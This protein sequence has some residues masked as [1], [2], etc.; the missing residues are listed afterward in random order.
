MIKIQTTN[1]F[2]KF[3]T[4]ALEKNH[5]KTVW[6]V[7]NLD[8]KEWDL[9]TDQHENYIKYYEEFY[10]PKLDVKSERFTEWDNWDDE[11]NY[12]PALCS[13]S[14]EIRTLLPLIENEITDVG[15]KEL[16]REETSFLR[17]ISS[18]DEFNFL[19]ILC[20]HL[21]E[22]KCELP[23]T[24]AHE[25]IHIIDLINEEKHKGEWVDGQAAKYSL[26]CKDELND[27]YYEEFL[28][29]DL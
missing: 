20:N 7:V 29:Y 19:I 24:I 18:F 4:C 1:E 6:K 26:I 2:N 11:E 9:Y 25:V 17:W 15:T 22:F 3:I 23:L 12:A 10:E 21:Q 16:F 28:K 8:K 14:Y 27:D 5:V 13:P